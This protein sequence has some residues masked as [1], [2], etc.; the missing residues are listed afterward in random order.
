MLPVDAHLK[1]QMVAGADAGAA[2][3]ADDEGFG[4]R[5]I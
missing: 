4:G 3:P 1:V 2:C 5:V